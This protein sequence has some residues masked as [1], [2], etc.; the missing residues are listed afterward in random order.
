MDRNAN[1]SQRNMICGM[2]YQHP[3]GNMQNFKDF[4]NS[5]IEK[6]DREN[7]FCISLGDFNIDLLKLDSHP[8]T[9]DF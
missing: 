2:I 6:I 8:D 7:K 1:E 3:H 9:E 4:L 5:A